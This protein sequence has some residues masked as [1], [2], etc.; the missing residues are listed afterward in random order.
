MRTENIYSTPKNRRR[1]GF[2][3]CKIDSIEE[4]KYHILNA[5]MECV[6]VCVIEKTEENK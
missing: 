1:T 2:L 3:I 4:K 5:P 6:R